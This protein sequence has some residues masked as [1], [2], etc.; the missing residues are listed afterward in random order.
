MWR[1]IF[2]SGVYSMCLWWI[3]YS[4]G[5][6]LFVCLFLSPCIQG[7]R[8]Y[9]WIMFL[10]LAMWL[11]FGQWGSGK[12]ASW[13]LKNTYASALFLLL[14]LHSGWSQ[15][16]VA[17]WHKCNPPFHCLQPIDSHLTWE[18][19]CWWPTSPQLT[20]DVWTSLVGVFEPDP[21]LNNNFADL[22]AK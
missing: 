9:L 22:W 6:Y 8:S 16:A 7:L 10:D 20:A 14:F 12:T 19:H 2:S 15:V 18:S 1:F 5:S 17:Y 21:G 3:S 13:A 4:N 11:F